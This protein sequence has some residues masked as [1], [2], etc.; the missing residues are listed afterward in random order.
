VRN[1]LS[2][3]DSRFLDSARNDRNK[4]I[5]DDRSIGNRVSSMAA[6]MP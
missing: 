6:S 3:R 2:S 4:R 5:K 1:L